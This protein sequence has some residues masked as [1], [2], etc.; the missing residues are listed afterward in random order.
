[1][2]KAGIL[3]ILIL[4]LT[5]VSAISLD[6]EKTPIRETI[7]NEIKEPA[8]FDFK[9]KNNA[10]TDDFEIYSLVG[11]DFSPKGTFR[12]IENQIENIEVKLYPK[13]RFRKDSGYVT[14]AYKIRGT[15]SGEILDDKITIRVVDIQ[16]ALNIYTN[17]IHPDDSQAKLI[18]EN[19]ENYEFPA[20]TLKISSKLFSLNT[21]FS[22]DSLE[23]KEFIVE[24]DKDEL[25]TMIAGQY[26][27]DVEILDPDVEFET[28]YEILEKKYISV[29]E[30]KSGLFVRETNIIKTNEGSL[31]VIAEVKDKKN[32]ITR[33]F[34]NFNTPPDRVERKNFGIYYTWLKEI[35]PSESLDVRISTSYTFPFLLVLGIIIIIWL[36]R[37]SG[38]K[39]LDL[40]KKVSFVKTK[41]GDFALKVNLKIKANK[42]IE[43]VSVIDRI[44]TIMKLLERFSSLSPDKIDSVNKRLIWNFSNLSEGEERV[45]S[46]II[47][48]KVGVLGKFELPSALCV[49]E[50]NEQ[51]QE[52]KSNKAYFIAEHSG[53]N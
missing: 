18:I 12:I 49:Y 37:A 23:S 9:I 27:M 30:K 31:P 38:K 7:V 24:L 47:Y 10:Q 29:R 6:I 25:K 3:I 44:P 4:S 19:K 16:D 41:S 21:A 11:A 17:K 1:M 33:L 43:K 53:D 52:I 15:K 13:K 8:V 22:L 50:V 14:I 32:I 39:D 20:L 48:S 40:N 35:K 26:L 46:Y 5:L 36:L 51:V 45:M 34:T 28:S 42:N 2:K